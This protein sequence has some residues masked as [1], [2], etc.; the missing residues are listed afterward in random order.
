MS[1]LNTT[2][3]SNARKLR[4]KAQ[5][6]R[7]P[8][9]FA[10]N[11]EDVDKLKQSLRELDA[12]IASYATATEHSGHAIDSIQQTLLD[13]IL[14]LQEVDEIIDCDLAGGAA[15]GCADVDFELA[16]LLSGNVD[17]VKLLRVFC[18][19]LHVVFNCRRF[20]CDPKS[21]ALCSQILEDKFRKGIN[22]CEE[23]Q[24]AA[25]AADAAAAAPAAD[26]TAGGTFGLPLASPAASRPP[27][28]MQLDERPQAF[29]SCYSSLMAARGVSSSV[30]AASTGGPG[31]NAGGPSVTPGQMSQ[32][33]A[34]D[35]E[36][37][38]PS[39]GYIKRQAQSIVDAKS[40]RKGFRAPKR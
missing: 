38:V 32:A 6:F 3:Y 28:S 18:R 34:T 14:K 8:Q 29:P 10:R 5:S 13:L 37:E 20:L 26:S 16:D 31:G 40:R 35:D 2:I 21:C 39:R 30:G 4:F 27:T 23:H 22:W 36:A 17:D 11:Q 33:M 1:E 25:A 9:S 24:A 15:S 19:R 12:Q 7:I